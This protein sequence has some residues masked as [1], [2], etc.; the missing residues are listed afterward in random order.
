MKKSTI[1]SCFI[2]FLC[3]AIN[4]LFIR[5]VSGV[6]P[7]NKNNYVNNDVCSRKGFY[8]F[9]SAFLNNR[10][11]QKSHTEDPLIYIHESVQG[12]SEKV[13]VS[14]EHVPLAKLNFP[15]MFVNKNSSDICISKFVNEFSPRRAVVEYRNEHNNSRV[16][17]VF[18]WN[19]CW[20]LVRVEEWV[21]SYGQ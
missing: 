9:I 1:T 19:K 14:V 11:S 8:Q 4:T 3:I 12:N 10:I 15:I 16:Y 13:V 18:A 20:K 21:V 7:E 6:G 5:S 17:F 2:I